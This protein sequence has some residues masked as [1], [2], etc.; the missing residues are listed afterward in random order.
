[1]NRNVF[2]LLSIITLSG[3]LIQS[4]LGNQITGACS[5]TG[6]P[7]SAT[8]QFVKTKVVEFMDKYYLLQG[9]QDLETD[10]ESVIVES[11]MYAVNFTIKQGTTTLGTNKLFVSLDGKYQLNP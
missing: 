8:E 10:V 6:D 9:V 3:C 1:M 4:D 5:L 7:A 11:G 2:L